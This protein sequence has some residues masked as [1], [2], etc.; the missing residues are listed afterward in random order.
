M[1][2]LKAMPNCYVAAIGCLTA[3]MDMLSVVSAVPCEPFGFRRLF[4]KNG[5]AEKEQQKSKST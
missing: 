3:F 4:T 2:K 5:Q 1:G